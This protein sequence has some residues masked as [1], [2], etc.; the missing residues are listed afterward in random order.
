MQNNSLMETKA[1]V[2]YLEKRYGKPYKENLTIQ[3]IFKEAL[4]RD[5]SKDQL[6]LM[7]NRLDSNLSV[8]NDLSSLKTIPFTILTSVT[9]GII[10]IFVVMFTFYFNTTNSFSNTMLQKDKENKINPGDILN[11]IVEGGEKIA[12][13]LIYFSIF[14]LVLMVGLWIFITIVSK[15]YYQQLRGFKLLLDEVMEELKEVKDKH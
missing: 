1:I 4:K 10:S 11:A 13:S 6:K 12:S 5:H 15:K 14:T 3:Q 7:V 8:S 9:A 2:K